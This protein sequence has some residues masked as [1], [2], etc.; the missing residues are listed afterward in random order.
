[1]ERIHQLISDYF[2]GALSAAGEEELAHHLLQSPQLR[3]EFVELYQL[4]RVLAEELKPFAGE[5]FQAA[6]FAELRRDQDDFVGAVM[7]EIGAGE[8][9]G[10]A[11]AGG[12]HGRSPGGRRFA[13]GLGLGSWLTW[14]SPSAWAALA[15]CLALAITSI[16]LLELKPEPVRASVSEVNGSGIVRR[17]S[18]TMPARDGLVLR[19]GDR[20]ETGAD[21][22]LVLQYLREGT[23][24]ELKP[25]TSLRVTQSRRGKRLEMV[26]GRVEAVAAP[27]PPN[28]PLVL[29]TGQ[30]EARVL[31][32]RFTLAARPASTW[33]TVSEG[34]VELHRVAD[35]QSVR[36]GA[37]EYAVAAKGLEL[38]SRS[39]ADGSP[40]ELSAPVRI[41]W[42]S[43]YPEDEDWI[44]TPGFVE[45]RRT[46]GDA[47][48]P[49]RAPAL[50][51][52]V[53]LEVLVR[54]D[55]LAPGAAWNGEGW[56]FGIG[57]RTAN[58][59]SP[60]S[61]HTLQQGPRG[62]VLE[63]SNPARQTIASVPLEHA[64][65]WYQL[66]LRLDRLPD[67]RARLRGKLWRQF[68]PEP[69]RWLIAGVASGRGPLAGI[70][71]STRNCACTFAQL[72][73]S[74]V[75]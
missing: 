75:E 9:G 59:P 33:L 50:E 5:L 45:Q 10:R 64:P 22:T 53:L 57:L 16:A 70:G 7:R 66:K 40:G 21:A 71:L 27:Q 17:G 37:G 74:L 68:E 48:H 24:V 29:A 65:G 55:E 23:R 63:F 41:A 36:V 14:F 28:R 43:E 31:G 13:P 49:Y 26:A 44:T 73:L 4:H 42:F 18:Q 19:W 15:A 35:K 39:V 60:L 25:D 20:I 30:A 38:A 72:S 46:Y 12:S 34:K 32:T 61:L 62:S 47:Y 11:L 51:G 2:D 56:G 67:G 3:A 1:M 52:S 6:V 58:E 69:E 54:V 8:C